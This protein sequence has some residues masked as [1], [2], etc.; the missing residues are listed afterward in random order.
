MVIVLVLLTI[1][2]F[3]VVDYYA[4]RGQVERAFS[5]VGTGVLA[6]AG[7]ELPGS[8]RTWGDPAELVQVPC[9]S[10]M[11][12]GHTWMRP[13]A[14]GS[15]RVGAGRLPLHALGGVDQVHL[16]ASGSAVRA[17]ETIA[18]LVHGR[19]RLHLVSPIEGV[20]DSVNADLASSA[21]RL[22]EN[23]FGTGWLYAV[24]PQRVALALRRTFIA[25]EAEGWMRREVA[26]LRDAISGLG[27]GGLEPATALLD[28]GV[29]LGGFADR[30]NDAQWAS[31][32]RTM[33]EDPPREPAAGSRF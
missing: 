16:L 24:R 19:R 4:R 25:E 11:A 28:G 15:I 12:P 17:G 27:L 1:A 29:P 32:S 10:Y 22:V 21:A 8:T 14:D 26:R 33:F 18:V 6:Q 5:A 30:L 31:V 9:G 20:I 13:E 23:P 7:D 2:A 3:L